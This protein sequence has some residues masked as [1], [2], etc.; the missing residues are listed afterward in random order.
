MTS[1]GVSD[2]HR[3]ILEHMLGAGSARPGYRNHFCTSLSSS[4]YALLAEMACLG[5]VEAGR[6]INDG[7]DQFFHATDAG[8]AAVGLTRESCRE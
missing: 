8:Y 4:D 1:I 7:R 6:I 2:E 3:Y 5:L